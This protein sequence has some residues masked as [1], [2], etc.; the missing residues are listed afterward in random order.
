MAVH[1]RDGRGMS[2]SPDLN[3]MTEQ[4]RGLLDQWS[5]GLADVV[6]SMAD[7]KPEVPWEAATAPPAEADLLWWEQPFQIAPGAA[8]WVGT[9]RAT[10]EDVGT[11]PP[12]AAR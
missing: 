4:I 6:A 1:A 7:Q 11:L 12:N 3:E 2:A 5:V 10:W 9:P 8:V